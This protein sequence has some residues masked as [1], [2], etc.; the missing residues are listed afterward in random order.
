MADEDI[1]YSSANQK[2][3]TFSRFQRCAVLIVI[4]VLDVLI[5]LIALAKRQ[6]SLLPDFDGTTR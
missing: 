4:I 1:E 2:A 5:L 3:W 6:P